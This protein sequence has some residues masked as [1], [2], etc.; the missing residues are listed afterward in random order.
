VIDLTLALAL[1]CS[2]L[3]AEPPPT[4]VRLEFHGTF[5]AKPCWARLEAP[6]DGR[7]TLRLLYTQPA[8]TALAGAHLPDCPILTLDGRLRLLTYDGRE[9]LS[10]VARS[11]IGY[12][13][14]RELERSE[15]DQKIPVEEP[16]TV[17]GEPG[18]DERLAPLILAFAWQASGS[19][20]MP[21]YDLFGASPVGSRVT[22]D[23][24]TVSI[25]G[26]PHRAEADPRGRLLRLRDAAGGVVLEITAWTEATP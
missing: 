3:A 24:A 22:W 5:Q 7:R 4:S 12:A 21:A 10:T 26:R 9:S 20:D 13:V 6:V 23:G 25:A 2:A 8:P 18:W 1:G 11:R 17:A 19:G 15:G 14:T 16:R